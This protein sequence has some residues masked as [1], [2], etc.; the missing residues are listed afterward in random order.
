MIRL[1]MTNPSEIKLAKCA[2]TDLTL[3]PGDDVEVSEP[4]GAAHLATEPDG[5][6]IGYE[7]P[8]WD[9]FHA[10]RAADAI[11]TTV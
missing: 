7:D 3:E 10:P 2:L 11:D 6:F 8:D 4:V 1:F 9:Y 5:F